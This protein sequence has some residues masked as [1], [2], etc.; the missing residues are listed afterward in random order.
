MPAVLKGELSDR[1][2]CVVMAEIR[3]PSGSPGVL[4]QEKRAVRAAFDTGCEGTIVTE[5]AIARLA[6]P[7]QPRTRIIVASHQ[8]SDRPTVVGTIALAVNQ[9]QPIT[10]TNAYLIGATKLVVVEDTI[11]DDISLLLGSDTMDQGQLLVDYVAKTWEFRG[12]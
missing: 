4:W 9:R 10:G 2:L 12:P 7:S 1:G 3:G 6:L 5:A 11:G 8:P